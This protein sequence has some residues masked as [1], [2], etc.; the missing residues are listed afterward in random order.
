MNTLTHA[1]S[2][3][4]RRNMLSR[5]DNTAIKSFN[6]SMK[7]EWIYPQ[8]GK[9]RWS[10]VFEEV[11]K[12]LFEYVMYYYKECIQKKLGYLMSIE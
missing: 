2:R 6:G 11:S 3:P 10:L 1:V 7:C 9:G 8:L 4:V 5:L 12:M